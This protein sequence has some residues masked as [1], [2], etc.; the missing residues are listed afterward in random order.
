MKEFN[1][2]NGT[3]I[4]IGKDMLEI[5]HKD[6]KLNNDYITEIITIK[7][8]AISGIL[9]GEKTLKVYVP[10]FPSPFNSKSWDDYPN[11][12]LGNSDELVPLYDYLKSVL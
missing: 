10:G 11:C 12:L 9:L 4:S 8:S 3:K 6:R 2:S 7:L 1:L 5:N